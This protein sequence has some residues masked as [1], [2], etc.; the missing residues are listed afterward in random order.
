MRCCSQPNLHAM[1][2]L[3]YL[4]MSLTKLGNSQPGAP[5]VGDFS[6]EDNAASKLR[7]NSD[8]NNT[9]AATATALPITL[10]QS[11]VDIP[12]L[13]ELVSEVRRCGD[14]KT[15]LDQNAPV[16]TSAENRAW[17]GV[18][19]GRRREPCLGLRGSFRMF[20]GPM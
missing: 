1:V 13:F 4:L 5:S 15:S 2:N 11:H 6:L 9:A 19:T 20:L 8:D 14:A 17:L 3:R 7:R 12:T 10:P 18:P 16:P